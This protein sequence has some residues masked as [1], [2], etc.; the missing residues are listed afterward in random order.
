MTEIT[1]GE[2]IRRLTGAIIIMQKGLKEA[3]V[4]F[5][6]LMSN[7]IQKRK[8]NGVFYESITIENFNDQLKSFNIV[9]S[10]LKL[11]CLCCKYSI[12]NEL[13]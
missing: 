13:R 12:P 7:V 10:D 6:D 11:S 8:I 3:N 1:N 9:L 4:N 5:N 2:Y